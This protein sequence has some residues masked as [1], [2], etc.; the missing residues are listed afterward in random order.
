[1]GGDRDRTFDTEID[2]DS[3]RFDNEGGHQ[4]TEAEAPSDLL[5]TDEVD[6]DSLVILEEDEEE[7]VGQA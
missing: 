1:M 6:P 5:P 4:E 7:P 2:P 3:E